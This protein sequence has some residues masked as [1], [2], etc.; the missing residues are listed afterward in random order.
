MADTERRLDAVIAAL[1]QSLWGTEAGEV[2]R[3]RLSEVDNRSDTIRVTKLARA[4]I[5]YDELIAL[6]G[7]MGKQWIET[8]GNTKLDATYGAMVKLAYAEVL[9]IA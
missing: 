5:E 9:K 2:L 1:Q 6:A 3:K 7:L 8:T 4:V